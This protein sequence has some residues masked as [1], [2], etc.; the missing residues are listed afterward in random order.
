VVSA[1]PMAWRDHEFHD[2]KDQRCMDRDVRMQARGRLPGTITNSSNKL[3]RARGGLQQEWIHDRTAL[4]IILRPPLAWHATACAASLLLEF[5]YLP[6]SRPRACI[7][8]SRSIHR[9]SL[10]SW[11]HGLAKP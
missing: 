6:G 10:I 1:A 4:H 11:T 5:V 9:W 2:I 8:T 7:R 3:A